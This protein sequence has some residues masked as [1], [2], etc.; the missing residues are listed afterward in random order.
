MIK[1]AD[2]TII[3]LKDDFDFLGLFGILFDDFLFRT[4][5]LLLFSASV[6]PLVSKFCL[7]FLDLSY[8][9]FYAFF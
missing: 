4:L 3:E 8:N 6:T 1:N 9:I 7:D 2:L 5:D